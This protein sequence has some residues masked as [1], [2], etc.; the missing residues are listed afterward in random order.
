MGDSQ[1]G[2]RRAKERVADARDAA[3]QRVTD[4]RDAAAQHIADAT[5]AAGGFIERQKPRLR[6]VSHQ[7]A[8]FVSLVAGAALIIAAPTLRATLAV[9]IYAISLSALF[10]G[11]ALSPR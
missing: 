1:E 11:R 5:V 7:W 6:G 9:G 3:T 4:A 8:F 2:G 10:G